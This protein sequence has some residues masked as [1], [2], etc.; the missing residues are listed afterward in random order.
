MSIAITNI[1]TLP[2]IQAERYPHKWLI[3]QDKK[4]IV[5]KKIVD[6]GADKNIRDVKAI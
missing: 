1:S 5:V 2:C 4:M 3:L 6:L